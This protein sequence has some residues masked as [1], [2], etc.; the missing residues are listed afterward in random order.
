VGGEEALQP[1][2][3]ACKSTDEKLQKQAVKLLGE[4]KNDV[5]LPAILELAADESL[6]LPNHVVLMRGVS[7]LLARQKKLKEPLAIQALETC[8]RAEEK[9]LIIPTMGKGKRPEAKAALKACLTDTELKIAAEEALA[10]E[11]QGGGKKG[12]KKGRK[13]K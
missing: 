2:L 8:R 6:S 11:K 10:G 3:A 12:R 5:A 7:R 4:W 13:K 1:V 9:I